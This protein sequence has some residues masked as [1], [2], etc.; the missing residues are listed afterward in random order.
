MSNP[1]QQF[2]GDW[3]DEKLGRVRRYL[4]KYMTIMKNRSYETAYVDA[5][6]GTGY[7]ELKEPMTGGLL[8]PELTENEAQ[9]FIQGS[10]R[11]ALQVEPSFDRYI[12]IE[13]KQ[14]CCRQLNDLREEF[15][16]MADRIG[17]EH[18]DAN[19][20]LV[21]FCNRT[22][23]RRSRAVVFLDPFGMAV[24]WNTIECI[25]RTCAIDLWYLFPLG[26]AVGRL[27]KADGE[28]PKA[29]RDGVDR[30][31]GAKDWYEKFYCNRKDAG[32]FGDIE[33]QEKVADYDSIAQYFVNR[34]KTIF[35]GVAENPLQLFNRKGV[36]LFLLCFAS[37]NPNAKAAVRIAK[38]IL[39]MPSG[40]GGSLRS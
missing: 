24:E 4:D 2:G 13:K 18:G 22:D 14:N 10:A 8:F 12:L 40:R 26:V 37:A 9:S 33:V 3:T 27:L 29:W 5:F 15:P 6:A 39:G 17:I 19:E 25:A 7:I 34:L 23:W 35:P 32:L 1:R 21:D 20:R 31:F 36:P 38:H 16:L 30:L 11:L 28:I